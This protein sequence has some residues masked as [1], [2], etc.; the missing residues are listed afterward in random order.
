MPGL[1]K[2]DLEAM[3]IDRIYKIIWWIA[4]FV[5]G[6]ICFGIICN[7]YVKLNEDPAWLKLSLSLI[8]LVVYFI[9]PGYLLVLSEKRHRR[10][11]KDFA[12]RLAKIEKMIDPDRSTSGLLEDGSDPRSGTN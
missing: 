4:A 12:S 9:G 1:T 2:N 11:I 7:T 3:K 5:S 10:F 8:G 6:T